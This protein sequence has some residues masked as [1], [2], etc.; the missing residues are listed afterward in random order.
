MGPRR[1]L[2]GKVLVP[3]EVSVLGKILVWSQVPGRIL[4]LAV[5]FWVKAS[6]RRVLCYVSVPNTVLVLG[7]VSVLGEVSVRLKRT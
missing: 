1:R 5:G 3:G 4:G 2:L 7:K 6:G